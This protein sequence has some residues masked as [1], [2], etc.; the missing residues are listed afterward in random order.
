MGDPGDC[1]LLR[2]HSD[3]FRYGHRRAQGV[4]STDSEERVVNYAQQEKPQSNNVN[5]PL[6]TGQVLNNR[7]RIDALL[8]KG[9][10][11]AVYRAWDSNLKM[12]VAVK[13]NFVAS[14]EAQRQFEREAGILA[15]LSHPS[16]PRVTDYFFVSGQGQYLV[17]DFV[18]GKDLQ[19]MLDQLGTL[20]EPQ[21]L[22]WVTQ[23]CDALAY[24]HGQPSPIIHRDIKPANI[25]IRSD[26]R[27][28][29]VDFG[30]AKVYDPTT[31]TTVGAKAVTPGYSPPEQY[32][33]GATDTRSDIYA[34]G[35]T[36][37]HLLTGQLPPESIHRMVR[38][39]TMPL[40]HQLNR[41]ITPL[42]EQAI[43]KAVEITTDR[44]FQSVKE[45][46]AALTTRP[47]TSQSAPLAPP[48]Q[49]APVQ[50]PPQKRKPRMGLWL[51][52]AG[53][54]G[55]LLI[56]LVVGALALSGIFTAS[57]PT[58]TTMDTVLVTDVPTTEIESALQTDT[59]TST[60]KVTEPPP[61]TAPTSPPQ[62]T[63]TPSCLDVSGPFATVWDVVQGEIGCATG[64]VIDGSIVEESFEGGKMFWR[65]P[66]DTAQALVLFNDGTWRIFQHS[67]FVEGS[68]DFSCPD[69][70][71]PSQCPPTPKRGFGMMWCDIPEIRGGLGDATNCERGYQG[72]MQEF[73]R[74]SMLQTDDGTIF[75]FYDGGG[76]ER[77]STVALQ[78]TVA[79][80]TVPLGAA[81][82]GS[83][84]FTS[85]PTGDVTLGG[86][87]F[88]LSESV[89]K[90]Q[91]SPSPNG[92]YP[93]SVLLSMDVPQARRV[94]LLLNAGNG[95]SQFNGKTIGQVVAHCGGDSIPVTDLQLGQEVREW[96]AANNVVS[97]ASRAQQVW[98]GALA[99]FPDLTGYIDMLSLDLPSACQDGRLTAVEVIDSSASTVNSLDP[100]LNLIG[101]TVEYYQ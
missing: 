47:A 27:A 89:F 14:P 77:P 39:T 71:T 37:Y 63:S 48:Q 31:S 17:M 28:M 40:P 36:L 88:Q 84:D 30:I 2:E 98:S 66:V 55:L 21:V 73:E 52:V 99:D 81:A 92:G 83:L 93:T 29:L 78:P 24:L 1:Q 65:E 19:V 38:A 32:G 8:G 94:H 96:H 58:P 76:W 50:P 69:A 75:V 86:V 9:G 64:N 45:F 20:P 10:M 85:P 67:P 26:G 18:E 80:K 43:L 54:V 7:Y 13:V 101:V 11:G 34:L 33:I 59:S 15:R 41:D 35:A 97:T 70:N 79:Y 53:G 82:N 5:M 42:A 56:G 16:L 22:T 23:V 57:G 60:P 46:R 90:S 62:P 91:A 49:P 72:A 6:S 12:P 44:R 61:T 3:G 87:P 95:F 51:G 4:P 68:P 100:A 74:G 25:K